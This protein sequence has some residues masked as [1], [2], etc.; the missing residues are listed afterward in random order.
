M[1][2]FIQISLKRVPIWTFGIYINIGFD[3][4][5]LVDGYDLKQYQPSTNTLPARDFG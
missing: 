1:H 2:L 5:K 4:N 3:I